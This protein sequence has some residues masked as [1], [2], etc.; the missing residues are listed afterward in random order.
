VTAHPDVIGDLDRLGLDYEVMDCDPELADTAQFCEAYGVAPEESANAILV[1]SKKPEGHHAVCVALAHT[2]LD[3]NGAV[4]RK[5]GVR[6][7]SFAPA[8][9][10]RELTGQEIGGVTIFGLP[11]GVPVWLDARV[12]ACASVVVG[13]GSRSA[14]IRLDPS[15][16]VGVDG[17]EFV[18]DLAI[19][20]A[21]SFEPA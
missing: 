5:L 14:K 16:L 15:Q 2:R 7:L 19:E 8:D 1:A 12:L 13:A 17:Y 10:T 3:V 21:A 4:R 9:L 20:A 18:D 11:D 6:K